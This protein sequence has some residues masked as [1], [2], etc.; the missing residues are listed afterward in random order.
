MAHSCCGCRGP[1]VSGVDSMEDKRPR[2]E[3]FP[4]HI[5]GRAPRPADVL[6]PTQTFALAIPCSGNNP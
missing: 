5:L 6:V 2:A 1:S 4:V 3:I